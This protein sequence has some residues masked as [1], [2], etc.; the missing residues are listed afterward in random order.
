[1]FSEFS[2]YR[3]LFQ[4]R[5]SQPATQQIA[6][7]RRRFD[8]FLSLW[9]WSSSTWTVFH[10]SLQSRFLTFLRD[11]FLF[12]Q[13]L[14]GGCLYLKKTQLII[15]TNFKIVLFRSLHA[16]RHTLF[17]GEKPKNSK[18]V[19]LPYG[20]TF[21]QFLLKYSFKRA[22]KPIKNWS[23]KGNNLF[24]VRIQKLFPTYKFL[25]ERCFRL[26]TSVQQRKKS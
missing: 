13:W 5:Y 7:S 8:Q 9:D 4:W 17:I 23:F 20:K 15:L 2:S 12:S 24:Q 22:A 26:V 18:R 14:S 19:L 3:Q 21:S 16:K 11:Q 25:E 1:M 6:D 10:S